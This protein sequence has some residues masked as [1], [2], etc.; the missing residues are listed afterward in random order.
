L[1]KL[2]EALGPWLSQV[3]IVEGWA[4]RLFRY[5]SLAQAVPYEPLLTLDTDVA[6]PVT[7][8]VREQ[9]L[10]H[11]IAA[12]FKE[13]FLGEDQPPTTHYQLG[14][15][16]GAFYAEFLTPLIG[17]EYDRDGKRRATTRVAGVTS[18]NL[19]TFRC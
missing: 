1:S 18:Q 5:H 15:E 17:S 11:L 16:A 12:N 14:D 6:I 4:H 9:D 3:V 7:L 19:R 2:L 10:H 13:Q 8:E